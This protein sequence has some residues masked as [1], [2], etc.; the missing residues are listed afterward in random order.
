MRFRFINIVFVIVLVSLLAACSSDAAGSPTPTLVPNSAAAKGRDLFRV[1]CA[2]C[3]ALAED[4]VITGPSLAHIA[5]RAG[6]RVAGLSAED[7][8]Y[9]SI[10]DPDSYVV[11][12]FAA[13][14]MPSTF[15]TQLTGEELDQIVAYLLTIK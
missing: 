6:D 5:S 13:S 10:L 3:H 8:F 7:Y 2:S 9:D 12:G 11:E 14:L 1:H 15:A 4:V